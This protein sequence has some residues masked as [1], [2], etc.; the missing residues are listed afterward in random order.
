MNIRSILLLLAS[1]TQLCGSAG[2]AAP[3]AQS[4]CNP[5]KDVNQKPW[6]F[7]V[8]DADKGKNGVMCVAFSPD[9]KQL[10][11]GNALNKTITFFEVNKTTGVL[12]YQHHTPGIPAW[13]IKYSPNGKWLAVST[14]QKIHLLTIEQQKPTFTYPV[15]LK[16]HINTFAFSPDSKYLTLATV[17]GKIGLF[18]LSPLRYKITSFKE[19]FKAHDY[20]PDSKTIVAIT[21][22]TIYIFDTQKVFTESDIEKAI[23]TTHQP[24]KP[25]K[26]DIKRF[27]FIKYLSD[28]KRLMAGGLNLPIQGFTVDMINRSIQEFF[29]SE[30]K[31][32]R[33]YFSSNDRWIEARRSFY[34]GLHIYK[35]N[36]NEK[37]IQP[38]EGSPFDAHED[39]GQVAYSPDNHLLAAVHTEDA[40][41]WMYEVNQETGVITHI[42]G[43][44]LKIVKQEKEYQEAHK[45]LL[46]P[47]PPLITKEVVESVLQEYI[48]GPQQAAKPESVKEAPDKTALQKEKTDK[49]RESREQDANKLF[50]AIKDGD[51]NEVIKNLTSFTINATNDEYATPLL[52]AVKAPEVNTAIVQA[53][54][55]YKGQ[56]MYAGGTP[57]D[58]TANLAAVDAVGNTALVL[59][60]LNH[61]NN[62]GLAMAIAQK[63]TP[64]QRKM[65]SKQG[66]TARALVEKYEQKSDSK[67][68]KEKYQKLITLLK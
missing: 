26:T 5:H 51:K 48:V 23:V 58:V 38:V 10:A 45:T 47:T 24:N 3:V 13:E 63:M 32:N 54:L 39:F 68:E 22:D 15:D 61:K 27:E 34:T 64:A 57:E 29:V 37:T 6:T 50:K 56:R 42:T 43:D 30:N 46:K 36:Q 66:T 41:V 7:S 11:V 8:Y 16:S 20:S 67:P 44:L 31:N 62:H 17:H 52:A 49:E 35:F 12:T 40:S 4:A 1:F 55:D 9:G 59:A 18:D 19:S 2:Q 65:A 25:P 33:V 14:Q 28:G 60:L 53:I 21:T